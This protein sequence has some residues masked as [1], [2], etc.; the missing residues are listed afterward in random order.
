MRISCLIALLVTCAALGFG[1]LDSD[2]ITI[3]ASRYANLAPDEVLFSVSVSGP[4]ISLDQAVAA[5]SNSGIT[6][7][8][9]VGVT[10]GT[11][12][13]SPLHWLFTLVAPIAKIKATVASLTTL[14]R[15]IVQNNSGLTLA[16]L[17]QGTQSSPASIQLQ[18]CAAKDLVADA[19]AQA[20]NVA[21]AA[22]LYIGPIIAISDGSSVTA[23]PTYAERLGAFSIGNWINPTSWFNPTPSG[24]YIEVKFK[25]LR[26][27]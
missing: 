11:N 6:A 9:F 12:S 1:Q 19:L 15:S 14:Q 21:A 23:V 3:Q 8:N 26:Y 13:Q 20:Q 27:Q 2:T 25:L 10:G 7:A 22:G 18:T 17:V 5:L 16:F 4:N 24:C